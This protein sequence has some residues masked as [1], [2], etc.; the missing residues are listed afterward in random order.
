MTT[1]HRHKL[2]P[3]LIRS[4]R[5]DYEIEFRHVTRGASSSSSSLL[6]F[7]ERQAKPLIRILIRRTAVASM[8]PKGG[9]A[10]RNKRCQMRPHS[11]LH[12]L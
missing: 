2:D 8:H 1:N 10:Q 5:I 4:G 9:R 11:L 3:A 7:V 6:L 12:K